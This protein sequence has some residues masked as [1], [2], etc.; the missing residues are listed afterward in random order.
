MSKPEKCCAKPRIRMVSAHDR[1]VTDG[2]ANC[3]KEVDTYEPELGQMAFGNPTGALDFDSLPDAHVVEDMLRVLAHFATGDVSY[4]GHYS[5]AVF[6]LPDSHHHAPTCY[7]VEYDAICQQYKRFEQKQWYIDAAAKDL[8][9]KHGIAWNGGVGS[10]V[11]CTCSYQREWEEWRAQNDHAPDCPTVLPNFRHHASGLE[12]RWY[13]YLSRGMSV[14]KH[15][16][17]VCF[18]D[19]FVDCMNSIL[20]QDGS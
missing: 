17:P 11:H 15:I 12:I 7:R 18:R 8:C 9:H 3:G 5:N 4:A 2:C 10:A 14:N 16:C 1:G 20:P 19:I 6:D 13:K